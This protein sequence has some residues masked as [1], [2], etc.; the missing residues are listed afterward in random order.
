MPHPPDRFYLNLEFPLCLS[1]KKTHKFGKVSNNKKVIN[2]L[3]ST[4]F[5]SKHEQ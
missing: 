3:S 1:P 4:N 2:T 5:S